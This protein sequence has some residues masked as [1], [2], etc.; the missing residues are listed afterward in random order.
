[1]FQNTGVSTGTS[2]AGRKWTFILFHFF[3]NFIL[4]TQTGLGL[5]RQMY[6]SLVLPVSQSS[7]PHESRTRQHSAGS[8][9]YLP[10]SR[11][12]A[13]LPYLQP[14]DPSQQDHWWPPG[15][16]DVPRHPPPP[17]FYQ[18]RNQ[19][20]LEASGSG[21]DQL[22]VRSV[23]G[24]FTGAPFAYMSPEMAASSWSLGPVDPISLQGR[25]GTRRRSSLGEQN[26]TL[27]VDAS[28]SNCE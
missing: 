2:P 27:L 23:A 8:P 26:Q 10:P 18:G 17:G 3:F 13:V 22:A 20:F 21:V 6:Q 19:A 25:H 12:P 11:V 9:V 15:P 16:P 24:A 5:D 1:M 7:F 28:S 4:L 14:G